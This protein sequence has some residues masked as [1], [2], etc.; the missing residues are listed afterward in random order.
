MVYLV[1]IVMVFSL[2]LIADAAIA[3]QDAAGALD[4]PIDSACIF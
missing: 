4:I 1:A 3:S 2:V